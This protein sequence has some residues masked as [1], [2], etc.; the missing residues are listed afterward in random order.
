[1]ACLPEAGVSTTEAFGSEGYNYE[2]L[3]ERGEASPA[4]CQGHLQ[5][6]L[7][8][9]AYLAA[10]WARVKAPACRSEETHSLAMT[11][12]QSRFWNQGLGEG[13]CAPTWDVK[14]NIYKLNS[15]RTEKSQ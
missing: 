5:K 11:R 2:N 12:K 14:I 9:P 15:I 1:M 13:L 10:L 7:S 4:C 8:Q 6:G 3:V